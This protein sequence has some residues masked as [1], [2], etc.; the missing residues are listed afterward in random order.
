M[1]V[2]EIAKEEF[3]VF[4]EGLKKKGLDIAEAMAMEIFLE[5][6]DMVKRIV[7]RTDNKIDDLYLM[8]ESNIKDIA[9]SLI[10]KIDG[11]VD[12]VE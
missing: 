6:N 1:E 12:N 4:L 7:L 3:K 5:S 8:V 10:D 2:K 9:E 11:E